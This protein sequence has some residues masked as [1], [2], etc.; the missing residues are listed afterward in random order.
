VAASEVSESITM[1][2]VKRHPAVW[3]SMLSGLVADVFGCC[4]LF[5]RGVECNG[6]WRFIGTGAA[7]VVAEYSFSILFRDVKKARAVFIQTHC[8]RLKPENKT[9]RGDLFCMAWIDGVRQGVG[10]FAANYRKNAAIVGYLERN[11]VGRS[12]LKAKDRNEGRGLRGKDWD[13]VQLGRTLGMQVQLQ[14]GVNCESAPQP[15]LT[16]ME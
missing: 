14:H 8:Q 13:A 10:E 16:V 6:S 7:P 2:S 15:V 3:E 9:R 11:Y 4:C 12:V 5:C 1:A